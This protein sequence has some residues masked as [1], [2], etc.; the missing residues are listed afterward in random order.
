MATERPL[1]VIVGPTASG[2]TSL[3]IKLAKKFDGEIICADSRTIYKHMDIGTA[4]PTIKER[5]GVPHWGLDLVEPGE[6]FSASDFK[7]YTVAKIKEIRAR[8]KIPF[9]V[10]GTGLYIDSVIFDY[11][12]GSPKDDKLRKLLGS[13]T[14]DELQEYCK[15]NNIKLPEN[16]K[17]RRYLIRSIENNST[18]LTVDR[19]LIENCT[20][21]GITTQ[22]EKLI[23][24]ID[25][26]ANKLFTSGVEIEARE[27]SVKYGWN[28]E[29]MK[30]NVY[31]IIHDYSPD[32]E[33]MKKE[34]KSL[35][36]KLAK[37]QITWFKRNK[38]IKWND[39]DG[40]EEYI[41]SYLAQIE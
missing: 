8:N 40:T 33:L 19:K 26:R 2:K 3:A 7:Q 21:V 36:W 17:N 35:D 4:K 24:R 20:V 10:G 25:A 1:I 6:Y 13:L 15:S 41:S 37:R 29:A 5:G 27:L 9:L 22:K 30:S 31:R 34:T 18:R 11:Q 32:V 39:L 28:N 38:F 12:F 16:Y 23:S 14:V